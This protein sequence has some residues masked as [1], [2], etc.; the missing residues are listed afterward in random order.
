MGAPAKG[1][2]IVSARTGSTVPRRRFEDLLVPGRA[3]FDWSVLCA[4]AAIVVPVVAVAGV[5]FAALSRR[6]HYGRW[7]AALAVNLWCAFLGIMI[8]GYLHVEVF[9]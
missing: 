5:T 3:S 7:K 4:A 9:P 6:Q 8:R 1:A 2:R